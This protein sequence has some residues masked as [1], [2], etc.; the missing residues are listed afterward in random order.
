MGGVGSADNSGVVEVETRGGDIT[1][2]MCVRVEELYCLGPTQLPSLTEVQILNV[3]PISVNEEIWAPFF[4]NLATKTMLN[5]SYS[6][7]R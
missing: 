5:C 4:S 3:G 7:H 6:H 2:G 1:L